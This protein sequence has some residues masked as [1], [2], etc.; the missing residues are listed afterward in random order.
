LLS[1][2]HDISH[3]IAK[4]IQLPAM[5]LIGLGNL[6]Q[7][8]YGHTQIA[9]PNPKVMVGARYNLNCDVVQ[10]NNAPT[11]EG[12]GGRIGI[13]ESAGKARIGNHLPSVLLSNLNG[14]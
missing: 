10:P 8:P 14:I 7:T 2:L 6:A 3:G 4:T 13:V 9:N 1:E 5:S 12:V 11:P